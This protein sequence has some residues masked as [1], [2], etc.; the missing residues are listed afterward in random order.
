MLLRY[1]KATVSVVWI[2]KI[3]IPLEKVWKLI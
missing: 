3:Y 1:Y 2:N